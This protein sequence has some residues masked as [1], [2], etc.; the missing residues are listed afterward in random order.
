[1][2]TSLEFM[3]AEVKRPLFID[4]VVDSWQIFSF[5]KQTKLN[6]ALGFFQELSLFALRLRNSVKITLMFLLTIV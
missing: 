5:F 1:M 3:T 2:V 6:E 4:K